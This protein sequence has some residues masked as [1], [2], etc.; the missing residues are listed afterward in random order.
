VID[1]HREPLVRGLFRLTNDDLFARGHTDDALFG[2]RVVLPDPLDLYAHLLGHFTKG[3]LDASNTMHL[4]DFAAV[5]TRYD[6]APSSCARH[7]VACGMGRAARYVL[8]LAAEIAGDT[9]ARETLAAL[10]F[11]PLGDVLALAARRAFAG[12]PRAAQVL[13]LHA[14]AETLPRGARSG[15]RHVV[16]GGARRL[17]RINRRPSPSSARR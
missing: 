8:A 17:E 6:L 14:L 12:G 1:L 15:A 9:H 4:A 7:L 2:A 16:E 13:A 5:A 11:D 3:R 10:P